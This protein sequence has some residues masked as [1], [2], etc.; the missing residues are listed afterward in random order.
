MY[1]QTVY[2]S[3]KKGDS[4]PP[5]PAAW[6]NPLIFSKCHYAP[7]PMLFLGHVKSGIDIVSK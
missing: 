1:R 5:F 7:M 4:D 2:I 6:S 3:A